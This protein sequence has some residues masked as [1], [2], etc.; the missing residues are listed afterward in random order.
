MVHK[1]PFQ[2]SDKNWPAYVLIIIIWLASLC[3]DAIQNLFPVHFM[4]PV[5]KGLIFENS[6]CSCMLDVLKIA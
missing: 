2:I 1:S 6:S 5:A 4:E 3:V